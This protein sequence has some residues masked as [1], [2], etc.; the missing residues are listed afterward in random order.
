MNF[1]KSISALLLAS[2]LFV[3][4]KEKSTEDVSDSATETGAPKV[5]KE[6]AATNLQTASFTIK[7]MTCAIGCAKTI[8]EELN[9]LDGVQ[10]A[11][12]DFEKESATVSFDKTI[13]TPKKLT[14]VVEATA[15]GKSYKVL[16]M[17]I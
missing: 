1:I 4:C 8:Q 6:I 12:V 14:K 17:K 16:N 2:L 5:K 10:T 11:T 9:G 7:G 13:L 3:G 15:D